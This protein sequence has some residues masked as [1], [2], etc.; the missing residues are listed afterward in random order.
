MFSPSQRKSVSS[1]GLLGRATSGVT[2]MPLEANLRSEFPWTSEE[3]GGLAAPGGSRRDMK[4]SRLARG[5]RLRPVCEAR[6]A[7]PEPPYRE[8][9]LD[10]HVRWHR[11]PGSQE[12]VVKVTSLRAPPSS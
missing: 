4:G 9:G 10:C 5:S 11:G 1:R 2:F 7:L 3:S 8:D 6:T 12:A